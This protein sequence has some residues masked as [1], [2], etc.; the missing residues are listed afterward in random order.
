MK[1]K[2]IRN[3]EEEHLGTPGAWKKA[4]INGQLKKEELI[5]E[6]KK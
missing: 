4:S 1:E 5:Q 3:N 2:R 6:A